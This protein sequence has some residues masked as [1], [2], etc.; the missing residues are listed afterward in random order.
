MKA[1]SNEEFIKVV[2][3]LRLAFSYFTPRE[4]DEIGQKVAEFYGISKRKFKEVNIVSPM[5]V[6][7]GTKLDKFVVDIID[8]EVL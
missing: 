6:D 1:I 5:I 8:E 7:L 2:P 3:E 4:I